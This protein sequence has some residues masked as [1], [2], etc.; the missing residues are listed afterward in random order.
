MQEGGEL[1][2][3]GARG[4]VFQAGNALSPWPLRF[5][6]TKLG[7]ATGPGQTLPHAAE[8]GREPETERG[9]GI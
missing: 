2:S 9:N 7:R 3:E 5:I 8:T 1:F 4:W 6:T